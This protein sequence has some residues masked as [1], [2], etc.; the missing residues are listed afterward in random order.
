MHSQPGPEQKLQRR[1]RCREKQ[2][3]VFGVQHS[4]KGNAKGAMAT[5]AQQKA[6]RTCSVCKDGR[7][8]FLPAN[9]CL[10]CKCEVQGEGKHLETQAGVADMSARVPARRRN[11]KE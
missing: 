7:S 1:Q 5:S 9:S 4:T 3:D 8:G 6:A 10:R 11:M 2:Q